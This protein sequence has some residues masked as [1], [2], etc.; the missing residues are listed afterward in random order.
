MFLQGPLST[1]TYWNFLDW[2]PETSNRL[3]QILILTK[4]SDHFKTY[5]TA[6]VT[7]WEST[8]RDDWLHGSSTCRSVVAKVFRAGLFSSCQGD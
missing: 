5:R 1:V 8:Q 7:S 2:K 6:R 4:Q 3:V